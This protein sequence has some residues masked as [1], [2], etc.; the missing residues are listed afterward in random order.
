MIIQQVFIMLLQ[1][2]IHEQTPPYYVHHWA[3]YFGTSSNGVLGGDRTVCQAGRV[4]GIR[5][6]GLCSLSTVFLQDFFGAFQKL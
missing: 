2:A 5:I 3:L 1:S 4:Q 6:I